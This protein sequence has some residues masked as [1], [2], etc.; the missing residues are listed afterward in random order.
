MEKPGSQARTASS[1]VLWL[2]GTQRP[3]CQPGLSEVW[4]DGET[5]CSPV[6]HTNAPVPGSS[7]WM[8]T[9]GRSSWS[10]PYLPLTLVFGVWHSFTEPC[11]RVSD[12]LSW[13][14]APRAPLCPFESTRS[15]DPQ[16]PLASP[17]AASPSLPRNT[18]F[19]CCFSVYT[20]F[21]KLNDVI[22][23]LCGQS[24][25]RSIRSQVWKK[26]MELGV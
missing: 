4:G 15:P 12:G 24:E 7:S 2:L 6:T 22:E 20:T 14:S 10:S 11:V 18:I 8:D 3:A 17:S 5:G 9:V 23:P 1:N 13:L 25:K 16:P 26:Q 21:K 19:L